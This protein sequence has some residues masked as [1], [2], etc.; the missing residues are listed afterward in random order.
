MSGSAKQ[1]GEP[2]GSLSPKERLEE[3]QAVGRRQRASALVAEV[4]KNGA[5]M[6]SIFANSTCDLCRGRLVRYEGPRGFVCEK[7]HRA[8]VGAAKRR[9]DAKRTKDVRLADREMALVEARMLQQKRD[10]QRRQERED[11]LL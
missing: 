2:V 5:A 10:Q 4:K 1:P 11:D 8:D 9:L 3:V 7:G 6:Q